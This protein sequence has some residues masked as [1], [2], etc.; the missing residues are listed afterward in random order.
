[1][2]KRKLKYIKELSEFDIQFMNNPI[3]PW[4]NQPNDPNLSFDAY[5][6][7]TDS[8]R[9]ASI[10]LNTILSSL[11]QTGGLYSQR[12]DRIIDTQE[13]TDLK[14]Q[15]IYQNSTYDIDIYIQFVI[16]DKE[17]YGVIKSFI[18]NP[19]LQSE[20]FRDY[21]LIM[22]KEW[23]IRT[24]GLINKAINNWFNIEGGNYICLKEIYTTDNL[25]GKLYTI[26][27]GQNI[28]V[29]RCSD[30]KIICNIGNDII[31]TLDGMNFYYFN[32]WFEK[33]ELN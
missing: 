6:K 16:G 31:C 4:V 24:K 26:K 21:D 5:D 2:N 30:Y 10:R 11:I 22:T 9:M 32:Y 20:V 12:N 25:T 3:H 18:H 33:K 17:Y 23:I 27:I 7:H 8:T 29:L 15:R 1:M 13:L 14:I 19:N 28:N